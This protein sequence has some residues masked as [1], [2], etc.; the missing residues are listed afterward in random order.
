M[1]AIKD[2]SVVTLTSVQIL[3]YDINGIIYLHNSFLKTYYFIN[4]LN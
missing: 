3:I 4:L 1:E 2:D